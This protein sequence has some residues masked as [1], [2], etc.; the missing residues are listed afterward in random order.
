MGGLETAMQHSELLSTMAEVS[1]VFA[2]FTGVVG[3]LGFRSDDQRIHGQL[4]QVGAMTGYSLMAALFSRAERRDRSGGTEVN[5]KWQSLWHR[6]VHTSYPWAGGAV[7]A[8]ICGGDDGA[9]LVR[10]IRGTKC[11][12]ESRV[13][14]VWT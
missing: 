3:M 9:E 12:S 5:W 10:L 7:S 6:P 1:I 8:R 2:G 11:H 4:F 13:A 14:V